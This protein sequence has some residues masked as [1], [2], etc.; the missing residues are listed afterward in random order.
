[1]MLSTTR[2][3]PGINLD[4]SQKDLWQKES[5]NPLSTHLWVKRC[6]NELMQQAGMGAKG[7]PQKNNGN[8]IGTY[9]PKIPEFT[10]AKYADGI[11]SGA[12][13]VLTWTD[14]GLVGTDQATASKQLGT[15]G[16]RPGAKEWTTTYGAAAQGE[17]TM[18]EFG[19]KKPLEGLFHKGG[20]RAAPLP[21][22][23]LLE[24]KTRKV[25]QGAERVGMK[26]CDKEIRKL[27]GTLKGKVRERSASAEPA[28]N[29]PRAVAFGWNGQGSKIASM[30]MQR[31]AMGSRGP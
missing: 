10:A 26:G 13:S 15:Y 28:L 19:R 31:Q 6:K 9:I 21:A 2:R 16:R 23:R 1:M 18:A 12:R 30:L 3:Q 17:P 20:R 8:F 4:R 27:A 11:P 7:F 24:K 22:P 29:G 14:Q 25:P 5:E